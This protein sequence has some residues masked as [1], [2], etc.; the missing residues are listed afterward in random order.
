[1]KTA[2]QE[3]LKM[4]LKDHDKRE[5]L[6]QKYGWHIMGWAVDLGNPAGISLESNYDWR[7]FL[8]F[9]HSDSL[10]HWEKI[11]SDEPNKKPKYAK[12][13]PKPLTFDDVVAENKK[14]RAELAKLKK[15]KTSGKR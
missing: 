10:E 13:P 7:R 2:E 15:G 6:A 4:P 12:P 1:M 14:L 11:L 5:A 9:K 3:S 8:R